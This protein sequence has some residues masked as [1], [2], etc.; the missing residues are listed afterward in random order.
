MLDILLVFEYNHPMTKRLFI[1]ASYHKKRK[2]DRSVEFYI[3]EL[4]KVGDI[5]F[6]ADYKPRLIWPGGGR[7]RNKENSKYS[8]C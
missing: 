2:I 5:I 4:S 7:A 6:Y 3:A 1:F 8:L